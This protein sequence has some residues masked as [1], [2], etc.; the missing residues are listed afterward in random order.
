MARN[1]DGGLS[2]PSSAGC[3]KAYFLPGRWFAR[4]HRPCCLFAGRATGGRDGAA[5]PALRQARSAGEIPPAAEPRREAFRKAHDVHHGPDVRQ[6]SAGVGQAA[7]VGSSP[8]FFRMRIFRLN[9][10]AF[11]DSSFRGK[12]RS[13]RSLRDGWRC[14]ASRLPFSMAQRSR[15]QRIHELPPPGTALGRDPGRSAPAGAAMGVPP[16]RAVQ[17]AR[18]PA[19]HAARS[20]G[21]V[22]QGPSRCSGPEQGGQ[23]FLRQGGA[24]FP[25]AG[26]AM[27]ASPV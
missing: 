5:C 7:A 23:P 11:H 1:A 10:S 17:E 22:R 19:G 21:L 3:G 25:G 27:S 9:R 24:P 6:A 12:A 15:S 8:P 2:S 26:R 16:K 20:D 14:A 13:S 4:G 18:H